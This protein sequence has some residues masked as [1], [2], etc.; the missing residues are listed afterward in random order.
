[1]PPK[2]PPE[3]GRW[4]KKGKRS[5]RVWACAGVVMAI[6]IAATLAHSAS[7]RMAAP[8]SQ[9]EIRIL[10]NM[11]IAHALVQQAINL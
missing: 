3:R 9:R 10:P 6:S 11:P 1:M 2:K 4:R 8:I 7:A 5:S